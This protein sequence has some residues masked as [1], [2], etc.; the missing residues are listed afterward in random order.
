LLPYIDSGVNA[1]K[2][3]PDVTLEDSITRMTTFVRHM[4]KFKRS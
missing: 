2:K 3:L 1:V 4:A